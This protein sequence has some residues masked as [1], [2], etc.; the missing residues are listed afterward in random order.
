[1]ATTKTRLDFDIVNVP[2]VGNNLVEASAGTGKTWS[3]TGLYLRMIVEENLQPENILVV[4]F[5]RAAT[6]ELAG[7]IRARLQGMLG[8]LIQGSSH[9]DESL[10]Q[11]LLEKWQDE[12]RKK[13]A[14][15]EHIRSAISH[16]DKAAIYTIHSF[17]QRLLND[18]SFEASARF[19]LKMI[20][21][22]DE[23]RLQVA[24]DFWRKH[25]DALATESD[26]DQKWLTWLVSKNQTPAKLLESVK[27]YIGKASFVHLSIPDLPKVIGDEEALYQ[28]ALSLW[29]SEQDDIISQ[30]NL[31]YDEALNG[32]S[33]KKLQRD[34]Y[35]ESI[36][37]LLDNEKF[38]WTDKAEKC[39][40]SAMA[41]KVKKNKDS[42]LPTHRFFDVLDEAQDVSQQQSQ[43]F[44]VRLQRLRAQLLVS[45]DKELPAIKS[46]LNLLD[47]N[48]M[49]QNV[50]DAINAAQGQ[51]FASAVGK[52]F[53]AAIIDEFQD[54]D[55]LQLKIFTR[56]F[57][58]QNAI[59]FY[60]GDPKQAIYSF[61]GADIYAYYQAALNTDNQYTLRTN[62]RSTTALVNSV[63]ALFNTQHHAF[64]S[65]NIT[66][67]WV[68]SVNQSVLDIKEDNDSA[69]TIAIAKNPEEGS[70]KPLSKKEAKP[71]A[72][73]YT[74][75]KIAELLNK[76]QSG[77]ATIKRGEKSRPLQP[78]DFAVLVPT[79]KDATD[80]KVALD[81]LGIASVRQSQ[82]K[83]LESSAAYTMLR[84]MQA[85]N[86]PSKESKVI[87]LLGDALMGISG[88]EIIALKEDNRAW[89]STL[90][91]FWDLHQIWQDNGF[92]A[93]F[94]RW[95]ENDD[96]SGNSV[97]QRL[98]LLADGERYLTD[99]M[100]I[101]EIIQ[102]HSRELGSM[103]A[104]ISWLQHTLSG[105][106]TG[107]EDEYRLRLESDSKRVKIITIHA[108]KGLEYNIVF[109]SFVW[110][111]KSPKT[112]SAKTVNIV[113]AHKEEQTVIDFGT[114]E[115]DEIKKLHQ[116]EA[117]MEQLRLLYV[118]LTRPV[119]RLYLC[120]ANVTS[121]TPYA[122]LAWLI[123][124]D[125][126]MLN[127]DVQKLAERVKSLSFDDFCNAV[128][129]LKDKAQKGRD[130]KGTDSADIS[131]HIVEYDTEL[132][133]VAYTQEDTKTLAVASLPSQD[134]YPSWWQSS[135]SG[136]V[137]GQHAILQQQT[138]SSE[139]YDDLVI[140]L[141]E[142][143]TE[144]VEPY[145][146]FTLPRGAMPG[147][148]LHSIFE[149][150]DFS[151]NDDNALSELILKQLNQFNVGKVDER[152]LWVPVVLTMVKNTLNC[153]LDNASLQLKNI[154]SFKRL[155][156]MEFILASDV[157]L[158][159]ITRILAKPQYALPAEFV[160]ASKQLKNQHIQGYLNGFIDLIFEDENGRFHVLDWKS[161]HLGMH[162]RD[163]NSHN[164]KQA[165]AHS[166][167][168][169]Q[170]LLYLVAVHRYL[171][172]NLSHYDPEQ[173]LGNAWYMFVRGINGEKG[174]G[175]FEFTPSVLLIEALDEALEVKEL[176]L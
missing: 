146:I 173:H 148:A 106:Y 164:M 41:A 158:A 130:Q 176:C 69:L 147:E 30:F 75:A 141:A 119:H 72:L 1:M 39:T 104:L 167:Y 169:L 99:L 73:H 31:A 78:G 175:V 7:R 11:G 50:Y 85:V 135:F 77:D 98:M 8:F 138:D 87:E 52:Q 32:Q 150:W 4:T 154:A 105:A 122:A 163:Y 120:W 88:D 110:D 34:E 15:I 65:D 37:H 70:T 35:I 114:P 107:A 170:A 82:D 53:K 42:K 124:G 51:R 93:M 128:F 45:L 136:L 28:Q 121:K 74:A 55:P 76:A 101:S 84:L 25:I 134:I 152:L 95:L 157:S 117:L 81:A 149:L 16:F 123:Y 67:D 139:H 59:L 172:S 86:N 18:Y 47:F 113:S 13:D 97:A 166:H 14:L 168:Y 3:S 142:E 90:S 153:V 57:V 156:E 92:S 29:Q 23:Y 68:K 89:E 21:D 56:L 58:E 132:Q 36:Y 96:E 40:A 126:E 112:K 6:A 38:N 118:A 64:I 151:K 174:Q 46:Q 137:K 2:L 48:G 19:D 131:V 103:Q 162:Y 66:F 94:R 160:E 145:S 79:H 22:E 17:C 100:H 144:E 12:G 54:T 133:Q 5:T 9:E 60:V 44:E 155:P 116:S 49:I 165:M 80:M 10:Y 20:S 71:W 111:G 83:V 125:R 26:S 43:Q 62:Y 159:K 171:K 143:E 127:N 24:Q 102:S 61:R 140:A 33:Y 109:C 108:S 27:N 115:Y 63:N 129:A 91:F 161:N